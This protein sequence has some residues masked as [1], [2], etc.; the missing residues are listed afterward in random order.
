MNGSTGNGA[1]P[2]YGQFGSSSTP[3]GMSSGGSRPSGTFGSNGSGGPGGGYGGHSHN[4]SGQQGRGGGYQ[5]GHRGNAGNYGMPGR[6]RKVG[7]RGGS[8]NTTTSGNTSTTTSASTKSDTAMPK[9]AAQQET[10]FYG[11]AL[12]W[13]KN[14]QGHFRADWKYPGP[15][16]LSDGSPQCQV[17]NAYQTVNLKSV[18]L[19]PQG[20]T[21]RGA[22]GYCAALYLNVDGNNQSSLVLFTPG[23]G[24]TSQTQLTSTQTE[25]AMANGM[26]NSKAVSKWFPNAQKASA[27]LAFSAFKVKGSNRWIVYKPQSGVVAH[28][29]QASGAPITQ[30]KAQSTTTSK[31][32]IQASNLPKYIKDRLIS[33]FNGS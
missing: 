23:L 11:A 10:I 30:Q 16:V 33:A 17:K 22:K 8:N 3:N 26:L 2:T 9:I 20:W 19:L 5:V 6:G 13:I 28:A 14:N 24:S 4:T 15:I 1:S 27:P 32:T 18:G 25:G 29:S 21:D 7:Q 31:Q 12:T